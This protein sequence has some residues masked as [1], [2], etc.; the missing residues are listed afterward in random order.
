MDEYVFVEE[1][2]KEGP[3]T[4]L[5]VLTLLFGA[6]LAGVPSRSVL[7]Q[8]AAA[9]AQQPPAAP[10]PGSPAIYR[11]G[12]EL[13]AALD[14]AMAR[15]QDMTSA[16]VANNDEYRVNIVHRQKPGTALAHAGNTELHY[17]IEGA[18]TIVTGGRIVR[19]DGGPGVIEGGET[20]RVAAGDVVIVPAGSPHWYQAVEG[21]ITY[22]EVRFVAPK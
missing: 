11:A 4:Q 8:T 21:S 3:M 20:R 19:P 12:P 13:K 22:L 10:A 6:G 14:A 17:I 18:G 5:L 16:A 1:K 7:A 9:P 15:T 2:T